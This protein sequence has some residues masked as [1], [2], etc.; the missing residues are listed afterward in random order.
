MGNHLTVRHMRLLE[1]LVRD[2]NVLKACE[3]EGVRRASAYR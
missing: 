1:A 2:P 3:T